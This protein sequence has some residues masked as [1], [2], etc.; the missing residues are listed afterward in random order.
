M[1][2]VTNLEV[3]ATED[4]LIQHQCLSDQAGLSKFNI[5]ISTIHI[6][7]IFQVQRAER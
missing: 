5:S 4:T 2:D 6:V 1:Q 3:A 7:N